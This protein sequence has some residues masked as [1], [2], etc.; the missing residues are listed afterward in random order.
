MEVFDFVIVGGGTAGSLLA[1]RLCD[2]GSKSVC[3]LEA[4]PAD[5]NLFIRLPA[6]FIK[7][8]TDPALTWRFATE[9]SAGSAG[10]QIPFVQGK[11]LGGSSAINGAIYNRGQPLDFDTWEAL[12]NQGWGYLNLLPYFQRTERRI[13]EGDD[14]YRGRE[15]SLP[16]ST[17]NL[18]LPVAE[19]FMRAAEQ[20]G[21]PR[22]DDYNGATQEGVGYSQAHIRRGI[23]FSTAHAFLHPAQQRGAVVR[24]HLTVE[25]VLLEHGRATGVVCRAEGSSR[26]VEIRARQGV[27]LAAGAINSPK[28]LQHSGIGAGEHLRALGITPVHVL[29]GVGENLRDHYNARLVMRGRPGM[30]GINARVRGWRLGREVLR[31][32]MGQPN[33]LGISPA[34]IHGFGRSDLSQPTPDYFLVYAPGSYKQG[35]VGELD[36]YPGMSCGVCVLRPKSSGY[37]RIA[38]ADS[39]VAPR[40]QPN[41]LENEDDRRVLVAGLRFARRILQSSVLASFVESEVMPGPTVQSDDE[42]LDF[43]RQTGATSY[44]FAGSCKMGPSSD[45]MAVVDSQLRV[46]GIEGLRIVDASVMPTLVSANT[47]AATLAIA[48]KAADMILGRQPLPRAALHVREPHESRSLSA[49]RER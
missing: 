41:Y 1:A 36:H 10:R 28:I 19:A 29:P 24:T 5:K 18:R 12:G 20:C 32:S 17:N 33:V 6:G 49:S 15:G 47:C 7:T 8:L 3:V 25:R 23:R 21:L 2:A 9:P 48:E 40:I 39:A 35:R 44:H 22:N 43:A 14:R 27:V 31:W 38:S 11:V 26:N 34:L 4:G 30:D 37:V 45:T 46:H 16:V 13:G 42:L